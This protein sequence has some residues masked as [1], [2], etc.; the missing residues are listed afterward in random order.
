MFHVMF[1]NIDLYILLNGIWNIDKTL[2]S[3]QNIMYMYWSSSDGNVEDISAA[4]VNVL[5]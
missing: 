3:M 2:A 4:S 5:V 1:W